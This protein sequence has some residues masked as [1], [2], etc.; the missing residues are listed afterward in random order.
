M[1]ASVA[2]DALSR[3]FSLIANLDEGKGG[4]KLHN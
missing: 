2:L 4:I 1:V 3:G